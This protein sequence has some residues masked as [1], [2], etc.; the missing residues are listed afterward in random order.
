MGK[1]KEDFM[2]LREAEEH[3][4]Y[5]VKRSIYNIQND[6]L[7]LMNE[8][9]SNE[10]ELT[11]DTENRLSITKEQLEEKSVSYGY[12]ILN[13]NFELEQIKAE[14]ARLTKLSESKAKIQENLKTRIGDAMKKFGIT[15]V[16]KNNLTLSFRKSEQLIID[17]GAKVPAEYIVK[18]TTETIDKATL[19]KDV[20]DG[21]EIL[22]IHIKE[23]NNLQIK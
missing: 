1:S 12:V 4:T 15:N 3:E 9:E 11:E 19:K 14:I 20:K 21:K 5:P 18:K 2:Q 6:Y 17:E 10:G 16:K 7:I 13:Y 23:N 8:I 22:G